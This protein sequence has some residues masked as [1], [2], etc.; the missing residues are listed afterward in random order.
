MAANILLF[1]TTHCPHCHALTESFHKLQ[2]QGAIDK[3]E[4]IDLQ[5]QPDRAAQYNIR[6][7]PWF[8]IADLEFQGNYTLQE[9]SYWVEQA[10]TDA[11][12][13]KYIISELEVGHL[14]SIGKKIREMPGWLDISV[15][16]LADMNAPMQ[17]RIGLGAVLEDLAGTHEL[18]QL[19]T[20][21][22]KLAHS[23][24]HRVRA[25]ACYYLGLIGT[26]EARSCIEA[27]LDDSNED[28]REIAREALAG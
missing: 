25:D 8:K 1:T 2:Q 13:L 23:D 12:I 11:G 10:H 6:S 21:L 9:L 16:I 14:A 18:E 5:Q 22:A 3:L 15:N 19:T 24:D 27:C 7:V 26:P 17:A 20:P 28:V 4:V